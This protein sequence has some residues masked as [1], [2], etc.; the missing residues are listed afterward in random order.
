MARHCRRPGERVLRPPP[1]PCH[2]RSGHLSPS[3]D[4][5]ARCTGHGKSLKSSHQILQL[6]TLHSNSQTPPL[7]HSPTPIPCR[8]K[9][10]SVS[11]AARFRVR[12]RR[13]CI[14]SQGPG[15]AAA[16]LAWGGAITDTQ[17]HH[18]W[19]AATA[20]SVVARKRLS[21]C[22]DFRHKHPNLCTSRKKKFAK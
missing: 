19:P 6:Q 4:T 7:L 22:K 5:E 18:W 14:A 20:A 17:G 16:M 8:P 12:W 13:R 1:I 2:A 11:G 21:R 3:P 9:A 10:V 15:F